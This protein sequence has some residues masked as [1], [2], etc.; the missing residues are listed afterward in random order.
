MARVKPPEPGKVS[1]CHLLLVGSKVVCV[2]F[3]KVKLKV[4]KP[5]LLS[6]TVIAGMG[7]ATTIIFIPR[8]ANAFKGQKRSEPVTVNECG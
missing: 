8:I 5:H 3:C 7:T 6:I 1:I 4:L 2:G